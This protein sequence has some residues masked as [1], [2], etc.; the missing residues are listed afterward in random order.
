MIVRRLVT[1]L[2]LLACAGCAKSPGI[3]PVAG[4]VTYKGQ[5]AEGAFVVFQ[6]QGADPATE[7]TIMGV[8]QPNG[9]FTLDYGSLGKG[10]PPGEY[11]VLVR[12]KYDSS[13]P[14]A[15]SVR[16]VAAR[17]D[18]LKGR[19]DDSKHPLLHAVVRAETNVLPMFEL[20]D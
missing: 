14:S 19:Y 20:E 17:P 1:A 5:P 16:E 7:Q 12:W 9:T 3:Y 13:L 6:R 18:R 11:I 4:S 15:R 2:S 8:V 10:A